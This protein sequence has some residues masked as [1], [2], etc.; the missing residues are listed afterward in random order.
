MNTLPTTSAE[1]MVTPVVV[2]PTADRVPPLESGDCLTRAEFE[3][4]YRATPENFKAELVEG[5]VY[6]MAS[7]VSGDWH[8]FPLFDF[9]TWLGMYSWL[10]PGTQGGDNTTVRLDLDNEPQPDACLRILPS[11]GGQSKTTEEERYI[12]GA[13]ELVAEIAASSASYDLHQKLNAYR[14]NG[15]REYIVWRTWDRAIDWFVLREGVFV[16][17]RPDEQGIHKSTVFPGL[18]LDAAAMLAGDRQRVMAIAQQGIASPEH[19]QFIA[20]LAQQQKQKEAP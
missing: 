13:P 20:Q 19:E 17:L 15:V 4:R 11:H 2:L 9:I 1:S 18:W 8:G 7:P 16:P 6:V 10:T 14:R 5:V 3:R 12:E